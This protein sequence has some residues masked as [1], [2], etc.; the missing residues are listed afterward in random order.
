[1]TYKLNIPWNESGYSLQ[2]IAQNIS[3]E[4]LGGL[5][6]YRAD[7]D[8]IGIG[9]SLSWTVSGE[10]YG[11]LQNFWKIGAQ[12]GSAS[13]LYDLVIDTADLMEF[14]CYF[15]SGLKLTQANNDSYTVSATVEVIPSELN[16]VFDTSICTVFAASDGEPAQYLNAFAKIVA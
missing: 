4:T 16:S 3:D 11:E 2:E 9:V 6:R 8:D 10:R 7:L 12:R 5:S 13:F 14:E 15:S 1:M